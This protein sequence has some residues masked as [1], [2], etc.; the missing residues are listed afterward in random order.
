MTQ[1]KFG[2]YNSNKLNKTKTKHY[3]GDTYYC[4]TGMFLLDK[5]AIYKDGNK[6]GLKKHKEV[7]QKYQEIIKDRAN[8]EE[9]EELL[10]T[11]LH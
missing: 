9:T 6:L 3:I 4:T 1:N 7:V 5:N 10:N 2:L 11:D 8:T